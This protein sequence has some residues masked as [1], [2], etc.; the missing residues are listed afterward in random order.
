MRDEMK[1]QIRDNNRQQQGVNKSLQQQ[2]N[3]A[4][5]IANEAK[6]K[7]QI[8]DSDL[9]EYAERTE[10]RFNDYRQKFITYDTY[11]E[12]LQDQ[13][14]YNTHE[15][16][17]IKEAVKKGSLDQQE[18]NR[19][20]KKIKNKQKQL[21]QQQIELNRNQ[22]MFITRDEMR[23]Y[24][25]YVNSKFDQT[26]NRLQE[27]GYYVNNFKNM[28]DRID[29]I[30]NIL[31]AHQLTM[32]QLMNIIA[33][34]K[35]ETDAELDK[36]S[37][38]NKLLY[39]GQ[40]DLAR[41]IM[42]YENE[43]QI[44][45]KTVYDLT[46]YLTNLKV[47]SPDQYKREQ[48]QILN[49]IQ[50]LN[51][52]MEYNQQSLVKAKD[53]QQHFDKDFEYMKQN[54][55]VI[56]QKVN[57][58]VFRQQTNDVYFARWSPII[59]ICNKVGGNL[60]IDKDE[61]YKYVYS[62]SDPA[63]RTKVI[64]TLDAQFAAVARGFRLYNQNPNSDISNMINNINNIQ[65]A[66]GEGNRGYN[67]AQNFKEGKQKVVVVIPVATRAD[68]VQ[69]SQPEI[70]EDRNFA[71]A[72]IGKNRL[73]SQA[74]NDF[75]QQRF[76]EYN[77]ER[78][79]FDEVYKI[80]SQ[81]EKK[82]GAHN[83]RVHKNNAYT[84]RY[85]ETVDYVIRQY[86]DPSASSNDRR[87]AYELLK[88]DATNF[89]NAY[90]SASEHDNV[91]KQ[92][93]L[94]IENGVQSGSL[95]LALRNPKIQENLQ[96]YYTRT[97][98]DYYNQVKQDEQTKQSGQVTKVDNTVKTNEDYAKDLI[99]PKKN[100]PGYKPSAVVMEVDE[101]LLKDLNIVTPGNKQF[102]V[103]LGEQT[104]VP[105][106]A[107]TDVNPLVLKDKTDKLL[108][109]DKQTQQTIGFDYKP[110]QIKPKP[111][112]PRI[113][114]NY[115]PQDLIEYPYQQYQIGYPEKKPKAPSIDGSSFDPSTTQPTETNPA[116]DPKYKRRPEV[117]RYQ[118]N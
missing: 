75:K 56:E 99:K 51:E 91:S 77:S 67:A 68:K 102:G 9:D 93:Q 111:K 4:N 117:R 28:N 43:N 24:Q 52:R 8:A 59:S 44:I 95:S 42:Q 36:L 73:A 17:D 58:E 110:L 20:I 30:E 32:A 12:T 48:D 80:F 114:Y 61:L 7:A 41:A 90:D 40:N 105:T 18:A 47:V 79:L 100:K 25:N 63:E 96:E 14:N 5:R 38:E 106:Q 49:Y 98:K 54:A 85:F 76:L 11:Q 94:L 113:E 26:D 1:Q 108:L 84:Q 65:T 64:R 21:E 6:L 71:Q 10:K 69:V 34:N 39:R 112:Q 87:Q 118:L 37:N 13:I 92:Q 83:G 55:M 23:A 115:E 16:R 101:D 29:G 116:D 70:V 78:G 103:T 104:Q 35:R 97:Q 22:N 74:F 81:V 86:S 50:S 33:R 45:R 82:V 15:I 89:M 72:F 60:K 109:K 19:R 31:N 66:Y 57:N 3:D 62:I 46:A 88:K 27:L 107:L 53:N 2:I